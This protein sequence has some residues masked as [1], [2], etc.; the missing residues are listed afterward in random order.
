[1]RANEMEVKYTATVDGD[2]AKRHGRLRRHGRRAKFTGKKQQGRGNNS[3]EQTWRS[4][5][6]TDPRTGPEQAG[7]RD[8]GRSAANARR[9][10][11]HPEPS[12]STRSGLT[13]RVATARV[14]REVRRIPAS[15]R[16]SCI[17]SANDVSLSRAAASCV[18]AG[19]GLLRSRSMEVLPDWRRT[20]LRAHRR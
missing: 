20:P 19:S 15:S 2:A 10:E 4:R 14:R 9:G 8:R 7:L 17:M 5:R 3:R 11:P 6:E 1:M 12:S 13:E 16:Q 18:I